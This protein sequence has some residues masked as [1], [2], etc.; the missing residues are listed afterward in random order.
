MGLVKINQLLMIIILRFYFF[1]L[2]FVL[3]LSIF[4]YMYIQVHL[5]TLSKLCQVL[6]VVLNGGGVATWAQ[7]NKQQAQH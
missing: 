1:L 7:P 2:K 4:R 5:L 3:V 6:K